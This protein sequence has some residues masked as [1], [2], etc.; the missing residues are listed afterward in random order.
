MNRDP[1]YYWIKGPD[2]PEIAL[3]DGASWF[4]FG[5]DT[6]PDEVKVL[7]ERTIVFARAL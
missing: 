1:G 2:E 4:L 5:T 3:W 7:D 6:S